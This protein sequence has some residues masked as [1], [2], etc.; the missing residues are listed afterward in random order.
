MSTQP[1]CFVFSSLCQQVEGET[2]SEEKNGMEVRVGTIVELLKIKNDS[3]TTACVVSS[4][5]I[6]S[7]PV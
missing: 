2:I 4:K 1:P 3:T 5:S 6:G 7:S